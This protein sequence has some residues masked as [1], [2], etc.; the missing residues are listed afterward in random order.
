MKLGNHQ[1]HGGSAYLIMPLV[2]AEV[3]SDAK[4]KVERAYL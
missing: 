1:I 4:M 2:Y 3:S